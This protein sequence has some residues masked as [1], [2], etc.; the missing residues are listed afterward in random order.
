M[1][2]RTT[3]LIIH[4]DAA[5]LAALVRTNRGFLAPWEPLRPDSYFTLAGQQ[6]AIADVLARSHDGSVLPHVILDLSGRVVGRVTLNGI[7]RGHFQSCSVGYWIG[8]ADT[9]RGLATAA[10]A[11]IITAAFGELGLHRIQAETLLHNAASQR[12]LRRNGF[13][14]IGTAAAYLK[15]AGRWQ[16]HH[17]YQVLNPA[18]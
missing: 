10:V 7:V 6:D 15:I 12:V 11:D 18:T 9:G 1:S 16:D 8:E 5:A 13:V 3:R 17:L 4:G 2:V 14:R